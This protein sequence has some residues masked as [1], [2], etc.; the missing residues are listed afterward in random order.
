MKSVIIAGAGI[1]GASAAL[2]LIR[3]GHRV[4][5]VDPGP[6]PHDRAASTDIS[7]LVRMDY[8]SD[9]FYTDLMA[10]A[11][12]GWRGLNKAFGRTLYHEDGVVMLK[13]SELKAGSFEGD[14]ARLIE[15]RGFA[16]EHLDRKQISARLPAWSE[17]YT[18]GYVNPVG[19]WAESGE[20]VR[21]MLGLARAEGAEVIEGKKI[22]SLADVDGAD[23][24]VVAAGAWTPALVPGLRE[25]MWP[26][27]QPVFHFAP[28]NKERFSPPLFLPWAADISDTGWYGFPL[29][30]DGILKIANHGPGTQVDPDGSRAVAEGEEARFRAFLAQSL[31]ELSDVEVVGSKLCLYADT[32]DGNFLID[33]HPE[34]KNVIVASG[35]SGHGFKFAPVLGELIADVVEG[36]EN[37]WLERFRWRSPK[38]Q[39]YE[40]ARY[41][42]R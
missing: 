2:A 9:A 15:E 17:R 40:D 30:K 32:F 8:G 1:F 36:N 12:E 24:V 38:A 39:T 5:L 16:L 20:V 33:R 28:K 3:R 25:I 42:G 35:G 4:R 7:K 27:A 29:N 26:I 23:E 34:M 41:A 10:S 37:R 21:A 13:S 31:P 19:G 14:S 22:T 11:F 6:L 18:H